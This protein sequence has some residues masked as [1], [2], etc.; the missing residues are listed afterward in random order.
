MTSSKKP[1]KEVPT[2]KMPAHVAVFRSEDDIPN[3]QKHTRQHS[4]RLWGS[5]SGRRLWSPITMLPLEKTRWAPA[6]RRYPPRR[7]LVVLCAPCKVCQDI[8]HCPHQMEQVSGPILIDP[9]AQPRGEVLSR[10]DYARA[11]RKW[12]DTNK[13]QRALAARHEARQ[14]SELGP[15]AL[16]SV[17]KEEALAAIEVL[18]QE[19]PDLAELRVRLKSI[20]KNTDLVIGKLK[21]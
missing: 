13:N 2:E 4:Y 6:G 16:V 12:Q 9:K 17:A 8:A 21:R 20:V 3:I 15:I 10:D 5:G 1:T 11:E 18:E 19:S 7:Y 14:Q